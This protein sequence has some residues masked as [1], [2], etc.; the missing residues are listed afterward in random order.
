MGE[1][2]D[3][4]IDGYHLTET[5]GSGG[6]GSVF[7]ATVEEA[8]GRLPQGSRVAVKLLHPHLR[9][10]PEFIQ[11]FHREAQLAAKIDHRNVVRVLGEGVSAD[12]RHHYIVMEYAEGLKLTD[13]MKDGVPLSPQQTLE[14]MNQVCDALAA[15]AHVEDPD[16]PGRIRSLV[17][18]D[19][20]PDNILIE[21]LDRQQ[22]DTMTRTG[23][24]TALANIRV[25]LLDFGLAKDVKAL[26]TVLSQTGQ[27]LGTPAYMSPEQCRGD[28]VD[29]RSDLY[30]LGVCAYQMI[31]GT[32]PFAGPTTVAYAQQHAEEI[33]P[34]ILKR[35]PL[36]PK[37]VADCIYRCMAKKPA[38]RYATPRELQDD[39]A[40]VA[41]GKSVAKVYRFKKPRALGTGRLLGIVGATAA[42]LLVVLA[43]VWY[44]A[45]DRVK[46]QLAEAERRADV[47]IAAKDYAGAKAI[48]DDAIAAVRDRPDRAELIAPVDARLRAIAAQ[49]TE[50]EDLRAAAEAARQKE[51]R[52]AADAKARQ[53]HEQAALAAV[54]DIQAKVAGGQYPEAITAAGAALKQYA[55]TPSG[56]AFPGL[57]AD[58][59]GKLKE[60]EDAQ[61]L[62]DNQQRARQAEEAKAQHARFVQYRD[63]G[64]AAFARQEFET[65]QRSFEAALELEDDADVRALRARCIDATTRHRI[66]V[67]DFSITADVGISDAGKAVAELLLARLQPERYQLVERS[68]LAAILKEQDLTMADVVSNPALLR[69][70]K[71]EGVRYL[72][73]GSVVRLGN[74]AISARLVD[75]GSGDIVQT[76]EVSAEDA[77]G[78]Q[79]ALGELA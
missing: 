29:Q 78:L 13:L 40:R 52:A 77:R 48:L 21:A 61:R 15:A 36:C 20:K 11:R 27:A 33:P 70:R 65:A 8:G 69:G 56:A 74:L 9:S 2:I 25:K 43:G 73:L 38:D 45:T 49:A 1:K 22:L 63:E 16:E 42:V 75:V 39:L 41:Q 28:D 60:R 71:L 47:A 31:T 46:T 17:H 35:N 54:A 32:Q 26:S 7:V 76:A 67:A 14:I 64:N 5:L 62:A 6:M 53:E 50:Q 18:R 3:L 59:T 30:S 72:V 34:D 79:A 4:H 23:D 37:N 12:N 66:A 55:D 24:K 68:H 44:V 51:A 10:I 57:L 19:I 58:A